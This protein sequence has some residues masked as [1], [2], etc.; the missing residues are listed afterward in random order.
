MVLLIAILALVVH[1]VVLTIDGVNKGLRTI[2]PATVTIYSLFVVT[3]LIAITLAVLNYVMLRNSDTKLQT[4]SFILLEVYE[5][6]Y[7]AI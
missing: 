5:V 2:T 6:F 3:A 7:W 4:E 1:R